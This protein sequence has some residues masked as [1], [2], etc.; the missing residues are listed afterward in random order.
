MLGSF[1]D[2]IAR[3]TV[4][5]IDRFLDRFETLSLEQQ[6]EFLDAYQ[7][8]MAAS[9][10]AQLLQLRAAANSNE[11]T[12]TGVPPNI[13]PDLPPALTSRFLSAEGKWLIQIFP[14]EQ[15]WDIDPLARFVADVRSVDPNVTGTPLQNYEA[16]QDIMQSYQNAA[17]YALTVIFVV[18][19]FDFLGRDLALKAALP[20]LLLVLPAAWAMWSGRVDFE[21]AKLAAVYIATMAVI[22]AALDFRALRDVVLALLPPLAGGALM[23]GILAVLNIQFNPANLIVL[24]LVLGIGVDDG[25]HVMHDFRMQ[26]HNYQT[27]PS[28]IN[29]IVL[30]SL[31][32]M[33]GFG[34]MMLAAHRGLYSLGLVLVVGVGSCLFVSL[35]TVPAL[36]TLLSH[37]SHAAAR[38]IRDREETSVVRD[39]A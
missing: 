23:L 28:T 25:V 37:S 31:T 22:A 24:P 20:P 16:S 21:P 29:A 19:L 33:V 17:L 12:L 4:A 1:D 13:L 18:L 10:H 2:P 15:I 26:K 35:V 39:A 6:I 9:L 8:R 38:E 5:S 3:Q 11:V 27:S 34:S 14:A 7:G 36:L 30:T 32:S